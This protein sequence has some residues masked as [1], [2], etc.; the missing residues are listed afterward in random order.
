MKIDISEFYSSML[1]E[2]YRI[3]RLN[4]IMVVLTARKGEFENAI[5]KFKNKINV[6]RKYDILVSGKKASI[7]KLIKKE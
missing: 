3:L 7:Y 2:F 6:K 4:G 1:R 5:S